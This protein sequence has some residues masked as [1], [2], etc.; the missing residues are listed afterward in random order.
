MIWFSACSSVTPSSCTVVG[1]V[2]RPRGRKLMLMPVASPIDVQDVAQADVVEAQVQRLARRRVEERLGRRGPRPLAHAPRS[3]ASGRA[4]SIRSRIVRSSSATLAAAR[5]LLG[6]YSVACL[7]SPSAA[8][9]WSCSSNS[10][11]LLEVRA[12]RGQ[13]RALERDLVVGVVGRRLHGLAVGGDRLVQV[14]GAACAASPWRNALPAAHPAAATQR[15]RSEQPPNLQ[16][17]ICNLQCSHDPVSR[18]V[19]RPR[20]STYAISIDSTPIF[21]IR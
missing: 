1:A 17:A 5:R 12:R 11:A 15:Q 7:Y 21:R 6:S 19:C 14:A 13:H 10:R 18:I 3:A 16:S 20:P 8:S 9:S 4:A 2:R